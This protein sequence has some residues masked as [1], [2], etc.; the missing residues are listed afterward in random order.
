ME[1]SATSTF[2][3]VI[4]TYPSLAGLPAALRDEIE[5]N[6]AV[7]RVPAG[8]PMFREKD[9]CSAF[10]II[11]SGRVRIARTME[12]G[13]ELVLYE[14]EPGESCVLSTSCL[15]GNSRYNAHAT[16]ATDVEI[17]TLPRSV[18]DRLV[19]EHKPF[20][21]EVFHL[22]GE[23]LVRLVELVESI[24]F[25]RL[26]QRLAAALLGKGQHLATSHEQLAQALAVSRE[27]ISR[28]LKQFEE[29]GWVKL[30]RGAIEILQPREL[31]NVAT[32]Q[33]PAA[34]TQGDTGH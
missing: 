29:Q 32:G 26:D 20:R 9:S 6:L 34:A 25:Q 12:N 4:A 31:R 33:T 1:T 16:C 5:R 7:T 14:V 23:R 28:M 11:L 3:R 2:E 17:A 27:S 24:G 15:L 13:R 18:F 30:R 22:F 8:T 19:T 21:E 10:P